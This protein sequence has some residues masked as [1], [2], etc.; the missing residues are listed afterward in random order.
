VRVRR[1]HVAQAVAYREPP[2]APDV[3]LAGV[4]P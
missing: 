1:H 2:P 3:A 4:G